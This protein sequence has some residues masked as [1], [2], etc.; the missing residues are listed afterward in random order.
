[1]NKLRET[2]K[3]RGHKESDTTWQ[4]SNKERGKERL[5]LRTFGWQTSCYPVRSGFKPGK[6]GEDIF[7][8]F[9]AS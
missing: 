1:M 6:P 2:A 7:Q 4:L 8:L 3:D 5:F 9:W